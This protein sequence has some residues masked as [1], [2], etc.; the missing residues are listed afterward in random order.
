[1]NRYMGLVLLAFTG[2]CVHSWAN[3]P[4]A[5]YVFPAGA[6][7]GTTVD[8]R[9]GGLFLHERCGFELTGKGITASHDLVPARKVW[10]E[11]TVLPLPDS[12]RQ[13]DYPSD[14]S[15]N[16]SVA[17]DAP[18]GPRRVRLFTG[19][20]GASG[21]V[22]VVGELP[23]ILE[24]EHDGDAIPQTAALPVTANGRIFPRDDVDLWEFTTEPGKTYTAFIHGPAINSPIVP[25][26]DVVDTLGRVVAR[27]MTYPCAE[28][29]AS[30]KFSPKDSGPYRIR[31]TDARSHGGQAFVYRLTI[32]DKPVPDYHLPFK[33]STL[34]R[35][36]A[37]N[38]STV[39]SVPVA[40]SG[41]CAR[42]E[43]VTPWSI[44]LKKGIKYSFDL[45]A[46]RHG[47]P[48]YASVSLTDSAGKEVARAVATET[49][50][51]S[52]LL[53][54]PPV[55]GI[56]KLN[57]ADKFRTRFGAPFVY[58]VAVTD[59]ADLSMAGFRVLV[60]SDVTTL[61]RGGNTKL[62]LTVDRFGGF[63]G[64]VDIRANHLPAGVEAKPITVAANQVSI[65]WPLTAGA[66]AKTGP[67]P[68]RIIATGTV[69]NVPKSISAVAGG[70]SMAIPEESDLRLAIAIPTQFKIV[71]TYVM[72]SAPRGEFYRRKYAIERN[73]YDGPIAVRTSDKQARHLQGAQGPVIT[74]A[75]GQTEFEYPAFLPPW[76][77][78]GRTCRICVMATAQV[79]DPVDGQQR[80][81]SFSSTEQNQQMIVVVGPGRLDVSLEKATIPGHGTV[82]LPVSI[83]RAVGLTG[84]VAVELLVPDHI[85]GVGARS[86]IIPADRSD[87]VLE[88]AFAAGAGPFN[89]PLTVKTTIQSPSGPVVAEAPVQ[90]VTT[91][92]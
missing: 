23:E 83:A 58:R 5:S 36:D 49:S 35:P 22:F 29:D 43:E 79:R 20:G 48:L 65:D 91:I 32:T 31:I 72:T 60:P 63:T 14:M 62:K 17:K 64:P 42:P 50:D 89:M 59:S 92:P 45:Q 44:H 28:T 69:N 38:R 70:N 86:L 82:K 6:Q 19:Q 12:Q 87:T 81:V 46:K 66:E 40:L 85:K 51:P 61:M 13:E 34:G 30:V 76:M 84:P 68:L 16:V 11:G 27:A 10:F 4:I 41:T 67:A 24:N 26:I 75:P 57:V 18:L 74:V 53:F 9:V 71:S 56:Y 1:M 15:G 47:S 21:P 54:S 88:I 39:H 8:I 7:R 55:D 78:L 37:L 52:P 2:M 73:G 3:P 25:L 80:T 33:V 90:P 77:E